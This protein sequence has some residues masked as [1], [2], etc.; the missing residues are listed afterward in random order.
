[1]RDAAHL[2]AEWESGGLREPGRRCV[3]CLRLLFHH[4]LTLF[5]SYHLQRDNS[6]SRP[7]LLRYRSQQNKLCRMKPPLSGSWISATVSLQAHL[8]WVTYARAPGASS[9]SLSRPNYQPCLQHTTPFPSEPPLT[10]PPRSPSLT[11]RRISRPYRY[12]QRPLSLTMH[13][14]PT[15][16]RIIIVCGAR[17]IYRL[18]CIGAPTTIEIVRNSLQRLA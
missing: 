12:P 13:A 3:S 6:P 18:R 1:M 2:V 11:L 15:M 17:I 10:Q 16:R 14:A 7:M 8:R 5:S 9:N 4:C